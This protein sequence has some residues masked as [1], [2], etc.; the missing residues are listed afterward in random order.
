MCTLRELLLLLDLKE[1]FKMLPN[2]YAVDLVFNNPIYNCTLSSAY[3]LDFDPTE[4]LLSSAV[5]RISFSKF[6]SRLTIRCN[7]SEV[8]K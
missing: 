2:T 3:L 4:P 5:E 7:E 1:I 8:I 6:N